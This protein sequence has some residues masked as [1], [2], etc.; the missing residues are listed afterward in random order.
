MKRN[1][2]KYIVTLITCVSTTHIIAQSNNCNTSIIKTDPDNYFHPNDPNGD[3]KWDWRGNIEYPIYLK[4]SPTT[5]VNLNLKSPF[6]ADNT[7]NAQNNVDFLRINIVKDYEPIDGWELVYKN[8]GISGNVNDA[9][10][11]PSFALYNKFTGILRYFIYVTSNPGAYNSARINL[12]YDLAFGLNSKVSYNLTDNIDKKVALDKRIYNITASKINYFANQYGYWLHADFPITYDP[13]VCQH[14]SIMYLEAK[15]ITTGDITLEIQGKAKQEIVKNGS[16]SNNPNDLAS[17]LNEIGNA[18]KAGNAKYKNWSEF[19]TN[20]E[21]TIYTQNDQLKTEIQNDIGKFPEWAKVI[22]EVGRYL[23]IIEYFVGGGSS[24]PKP[25]APMSFDVSLK[26]TSNSKI[27]TSDPYGGVKFYTPGSNHI[28]NSGNFKPVYDEPLG[29]FNLIETPVLQ[30]IPIA[31][32]PVALFGTGVCLN[33]QKND[34]GEN[35]LPMNQFFPN[36][37][38]Y[39]VKN[40]L[41]YVI[42]PSSELEVISIESQIVFQPS[43]NFV[44]QRICKTSSKMFRG[45]VEVGPLNINVPYMDRMKLLGLNIDYWP[46]DKTTISDDDNIKD[47]IYS[48]R[49]LPSSCFDETSFKVFH[50]LGDEEKMFCKVVVKLKR[51][52]G[53]GQEILMIKT[54][55]LDFELFEEGLTNQLYQVSGPQ[56]GPLSC[57]MSENY[58]SSVPSTLFSNTLSETIPENLDLSGVDLSQITANEII[59]KAWNKI[60]IGDNFIFP[61]AAKIKFIAGKSI[62]TDPN[63]QTP[64]NVT[65]EYLIE[66]PTN[67][68]PLLSNSNHLI[69]DFCANIY[70]PLPLSIP[71]VLNEEQ[72]ENIDSISENDLNKFPFLVIL[73]PNPTTANFT[74]SIFNNNEQDYSIALMDVT[75]KVLFNNNYNGKQTSQHIET[76]GLAAGIYFVRITCGNTQKTEKLIIHNNQ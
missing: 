22:P 33:G 58:V 45:P 35:V 25:I 15:I 76:N 75:G 34:L 44:N 66:L 59:F 72:Q 65:V 23:G 56:S 21:N 39:K 49:L 16:I 53:L 64:S 47:I 11:D 24:A 26:T 60:V 27:E 31:S 2:L 18:F 55:K 1:I 9:V 43:T 61:N 73:A 19:K 50:I 48:T 40:N 3:L 74:I 68:Q 62:E 29:V 71:F 17:I 51:K 57:D 7:F 32:N 30:V 54:Y 6:W 41:K 14:L 10:A 70:E 28:N 12:T 63:V 46:D 69:N 13:C 4:T 36:I 5:A 42:N 20:L 52:D 37:R 8:F 38:H 67:C